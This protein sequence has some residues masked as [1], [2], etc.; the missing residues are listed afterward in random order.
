MSCTGLQWIFWCATHCTLVA[1]TGN[2]DCTAVDCR[3]LLIRQGGVVR[4]T[5]SGA[6]A[7]AH[8]KA[9]PA[10]CMAPCYIQY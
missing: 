7:R 5:S 6:Q 2:D 4:C 10:I 1:R 9:S 3:N 8:A